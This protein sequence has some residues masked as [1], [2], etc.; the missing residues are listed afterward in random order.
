MFQLAR[1]DT[2][3]FHLNVFDIYSLASGDPVY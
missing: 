2:S 1:V 3:K